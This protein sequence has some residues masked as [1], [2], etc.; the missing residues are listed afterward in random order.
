MGDQHTYVQLLTA[1][2]TIN[3]SHFQKGSF[4]WSV[5]LTSLIAPIMEHKVCKQICRISQATRSIL[6]NS[7]VPK[8]D[9]RAK[10]HLITVIHAW[11]CTLNINGQV[12]VM[13]LDFSKVF[14]TV[15][16]QKAPAQSQVSYITGNWGQLHTWL[17]DFL[18]S[19]RS[20]VLLNGSA[21][22][23]SPVLS[24]TMLGPILFLCSFF[25]SC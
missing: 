21:S 13:F 20:R 8:G 5:S 10:A 22:Q 4:C 11:A 9:F 1:C 6:N 3:T 7:M 15:Q 2:K 12:N 23:W 25:S 14:D 17:S 16:S 24:G 18:T 19:R